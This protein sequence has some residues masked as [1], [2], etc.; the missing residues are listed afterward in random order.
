MLIAS[1]I[2]ALRLAAGL[3]VTPLW[4][5]AIG[6]SMFLPPVNFIVMAVLSGR[7]ARELREAGYAIGMFTVEQKY[8]V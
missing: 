3:K 5:Y 4:R 1:L 8:V 7:A 2:G 6:L